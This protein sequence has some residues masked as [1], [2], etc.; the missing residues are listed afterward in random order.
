M[1]SRP[2]D[3]LVAGGG[4]A[5]CAFAMLAARAGASVLLIEIDDYRQLR[6]GEHLAGRVRPM[7][8]ALRVPGA[9]AGRIASPSPGIVSIWSARERLVKRYGA[10]GQ[11]AGICVLRHQ[12]DELLCRSAR[13]AGVSVSRGKPVH[14]ERLRAREWGVT[15]AD[16]N[17]RRHALVA[18]SLVDASG[19][20]ACLARRLG[21]HRVNHG[22]LAAIVRWFDVAAPPQRAATMLTVESSPYGWWSLSA[23]ADRTLVVT[24]YTSMSMVKAAGAAPAVWWAEALAATRRTASVLHECRPTARA[25]R[26]YRACPSR[27]SRLWGDAWIAIGDA[28]IALDPLAGQGVPFALESAFRAF[29][30]ARVDPSWRLLGA[31][32]RDA[33]LSRFNTHLDARARVYEQAGAVLPSSFLRSAVMAR[34]S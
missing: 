16:A 7:L 18:R 27:S 17:G 4:P 10:S 19:R 13:A 3:F 30:A 9:D 20:S 21:S 1:P 33:L 24:L 14:V 32:Y 22:D 5:G 8:D 12:F 29:E 31:D 25:T 34:A 23:V 2:I 15:I 26:V 28:A 6:P 11:P